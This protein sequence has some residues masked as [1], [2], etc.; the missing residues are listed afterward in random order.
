MY[1]GID[2]GG[3]FTDGL[4]L[5]E[6][7][8]VNSVKQ[9]TAE[10]ELKST[11]LTVLDKLLVGAEPLRLK[12]IGL[13]TTLV[14]NLLATGRGEPAAAVLIPGPGLN[15]QQLELPPNSY[16]VQGAVDFRG[17][18]TEPLNI[19]QVEQAARSIAGQNINK[20]TVVGKFSGRNSSLESQAR[21]I[22]TRICPELDIVL[23]FEVA[24]R[25]NFLRRLTT[26]YYTAVTRD[27]WRRFARE[28]NAALRERGI[29]APLNILKADGGTIPV[30]ASLN[31]PC[32]TVFSGPAASAMGAYGLTMDSLTSVVVDIGGTTTDLALIL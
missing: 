31:R 29:E 3:T 11:V 15:Y 4:L 27:N 1:I 22:L 23:G 18:V 13:S 19:S 20:V 10:T 12:R 26:A 32:E 24:G 7:K 9:P 16:L 14:T 2:V 30:R 28:I 17:R 6:G 5:S 21:D 8:V 25:L